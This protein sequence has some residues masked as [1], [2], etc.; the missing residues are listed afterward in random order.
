M[1]FF[2]CLPSYPHCRS[3]VLLANPEKDVL[4][5]LIELAG[6]EFEI[7][8]T[9][10]GVEAL[11]LISD[12]RPAVAVV[13]LA[14]PSLNG[15]GLL[16]KAAGF[17]NIIAVSA[18]SNDEMAARCASLSAWYYMP[19]PCDAESLLHRVR[20]AAGGFRVIASPERL[21]FSMGIM[22]NLSGYRYLLEAIALAQNGA[23]AVTKEIYPA[24]ARK[25]STKSTLVERS[26]RHAV[27]KAWD[28]GR[29]DLPKRPTNSQFIAYVVE[30]LR[31]GK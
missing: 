7:V 15:L 17:T 30:M 14:L 29:I 11:R 2:C 22:S 5:S 23:T 6:E 8:S 18:F 9:E 3:A 28:S 16:E 26:I 21:L 24:V 4:K 10:N 19:K 25:F 12:L 13:D 27:S 31:L 1:C 20:E